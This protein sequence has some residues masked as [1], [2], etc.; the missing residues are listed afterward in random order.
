MDY[1][2]YDIRPDLNPKESSMPLAAFVLSLVGLVFSLVPFFGTI[3]P[4]LAVTLSLLSRGGEMKTSGKSK[5]ALFL[6]IIG[7]LIGIASIIF[8]IVIISQNISDPDFLQE[9]EKIYTNQNAGYL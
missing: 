4:A 8:A 3:C 7:I 9:F 5:A 6:G 1:Q 2:P